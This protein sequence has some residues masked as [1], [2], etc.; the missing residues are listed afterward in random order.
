[1]QR[2]DLQRQKNSEIEN[3]WLPGDKREQISAGCYAKRN[4]GRLSGA[5]L[6][7]VRQKGLLQDVCIH[8][9]VVAE[10]STHDEKMEDLVASEVLVLSV[11]DRKFQCVDDAADRVDDTT[12]QEP[13]ECG[14]G[15]SVEQLADCK[16]ADPTHS[17]IQDRRNPLGTEDPEEFQNH[18]QDCDGPDG[19][20]H[21]KTGFPAENQKADRSITA[22][23]QNKDHHMVDFL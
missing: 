8:K 12:G 1:M 6:P 9:N 16:D 3:E 2:K 22:C 18:S 20:Q 15:Q 5:V 13:S 14:R 4:P 19:D 17:D 21:G 11:E 10:A 7:G 23:D